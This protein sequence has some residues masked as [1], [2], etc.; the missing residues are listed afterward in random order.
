MRTQAP[1]LTQTQRDTSDG[2]RC[3]SCAQHARRT[4][5]RAPSVHQRRTPLSA[6][7][8]PPG[9]AHGLTCQPIA[10]SRYTLIRAPL[11]M[12]GFRFIYASIV[13]S[14]ERKLTVWIFVDTHAG[15]FRIRSTSNIS[16][17]T[18]ERVIAN[19]VSKV[20]GLLSA[21]C[22]YAVN[23]NHVRIRLYRAPHSSKFCPRR[24][25]KV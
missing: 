11:L 13:S 20:L 1:C 25:S 5:E 8:K 10:S 2:A 12:V 7:N 16:K 21:A 18:I 24:I 3:A 23:A 15:P 9:N 14:F 17:T 4:T 19:L 6:R 22:I